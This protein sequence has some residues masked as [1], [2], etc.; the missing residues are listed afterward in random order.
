MENSETV[1]TYHFTIP[2]DTIKA[3]NNIAADSETVSDSGSYATTTEPAAD[4]KKYSD[5][6]ANLNTK[7]NNVVIQNGTVIQYN[8]Q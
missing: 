2:A 6:A 7:S 8:R 3:G 5:I 4:S 1:S